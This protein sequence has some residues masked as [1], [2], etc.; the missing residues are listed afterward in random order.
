MNYILRELDEKVLQ[1]F[2]ISKDK[3]LI[4]AGIVGCG[5]TTLI[6]NLLKSLKDQFEIFQYTGDDARFRSAIHEDTTY[7]YN[8]IRSKTNKRALVFVDEVQKSENI[9]DALKYAFDQ[10][11]CSFIVSGSNP[12]YLN[13]IAR[14]RLQRRADFITLQPFSLPE[15][16][17]N[18]GYITLKDIDYFNGI[19]SDP[20]K[21]LKNLDISI[22]L[23]LGESFNKYKQEA[24][25]SFFTYGGLPLSHTTSSNKSKIIEIRNT[26][27]RGF[28]S[29]S[30]NNDD[31][32]DIVRIE[33]AKLNAKEFT[34]SNIF[35]K[36]GLRRRDQINNIIDELINHGYLIR[37]KPFVENGTRK[38][39][40]STFS[41][42]DSGIVSYLTGN[43]SLGTTIGSKI[44]AYVQWRLEHI[45]KESIILKSQIYYYKPYSID[46]NNKVKFKEGEI[47]FILTIGDRI[48]PIE[49]KSSDNINNIKVPYLEK[50]IIKNKL[51]FGIVLYEGLP[52]W[53]KNKERI[54]YWPYWLI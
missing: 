32:N 35:K 4:L 1:T 44:E 13:T 36:T 41:Y 49:V 33:L 24:L 27:E 18:I 51:P 31:L 45:L 5:K 15:I 50:F 29:S 17:S 46:I 37:K 7:I 28:E 10:K 3:G 43:T 19:I 54:I 14:K 22:P 53:N 9:F 20:P 26:I 39:Y 8:D 2:K 16:F 42:I 34:Y 25:K 12:D 23:A 40:L 11:N 47:D 38:S 52:F 30:S 48:I 6:L 21:N